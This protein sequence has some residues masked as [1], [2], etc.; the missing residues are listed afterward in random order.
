MNLIPQDVQDIASMRNLFYFLSFKTIRILFSFLSF[1]RD[2]SSRIG[3]WE[4]TSRVE[5]SEKYQTNS[6]KLIQNCRN[7]EMHWR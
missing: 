5:N 1:S 3:R 4:K 7:V 2:F 6:K